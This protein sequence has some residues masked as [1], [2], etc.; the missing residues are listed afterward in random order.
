MANTKSMLHLSHFLFGLRT[1][2]SAI[3][4]CI[5]LLHSVEAG[6]IHRDCLRTISIIMK[7]VIGVILVA[8]RVRQSTNAGIIDTLIPGKKVR[9][10][11]I[12]ELHLLL[13]SFRTHCRL[14]QCTFA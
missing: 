8:L 5:Q 7:F 2:G 10:W 12:S 6:L 3:A 9:R 11:V 4:H 13:A 14:K 1:N